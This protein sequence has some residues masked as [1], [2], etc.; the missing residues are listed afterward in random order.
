[1]RGVMALPLLV[2][3]SLVGGVDAQGVDDRPERRVADAELQRELN[4][5]ISAGVDYLKGAQNEDGSWTYQRAAEAVGRQRQAGEGAD[6]DYTGGLT[7]L[8]LYALAASGVP[9]SDPA[10]AR[11]VE[12]TEENLRP[13]STEGTVGTYSASLLILALTRIDAKEHRR[14][15]HKLATRLVSGQLPNGM[16]T[17][18]LSRKTTAS[19]AAGGGR[20]QGSPAMGDNSNSQFAVLG[21]WAA[22]VLTRFPVP[23]KTWT[24]VRKLYERAQHEDGRWAYTEAT[25]AQGARVMR[26]GM[27]AVRPTMTAAGLVSY[28]C[29]TAAL[30][31]GAK[32]LAKA[33]EE[34]VAKR[35][36]KAFRDGAGGWNYL[37]YYL[38]YSIERVGTMLGV[39]AAEWYE[40]GAT[41][42]V[43]QQ[44]RDGRWSAR[45]GRQGRGRREAGGSRHG[46]Q[47]NAYE[48]SL[49]L[50]FLSRATVYP[51]TH[52]TTGKTRR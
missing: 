51:I 31:G 35:G 7:A 4:T 40:E 29:A 27:T 17:Y 36:L 41:M 48:T 49:A 28:V 52:R 39:P 42:L 6:D 1:M 21:L 20:R 43:D 45:S 16:W 34:E 32:G 24:R 9:A 18:L 3:S 26:P 25:T 8:A 30:R 19:P 47:A 23:Q 46:D 5:A 33:Q 37:D 15:I 10:I 2:T 12:W 11:G 22:K 14:R 50:L 44:R 38:V 13:F